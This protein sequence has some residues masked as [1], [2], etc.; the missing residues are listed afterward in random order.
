M[1]ERLARI[2]QKI[3]AAEVALHPVLSV[4]EIASL[5]ARHSIRLPEEYRRFLRDVGNGGKGPPGYGLIR[6]GEGPNSQDAEQVRYWRELPHVN[7]SFPF[8]EH[9]CPECGTLPEEGAE[10]EVS[11]GSI[12]LG[13]DGCGMD[14]HLILS[15][16]ERGHVWM[17]YGGGC[18]PTVPKRDFLRWYEDWL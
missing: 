18:S 11:H 7:L 8:T 16:R 13:E 15:G 5:E 3:A 14:W 4:A 1:E 10:N 6:L 12:F 17:L 2:K 9:W